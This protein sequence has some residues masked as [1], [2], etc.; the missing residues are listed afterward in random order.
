LRLQDLAG[1][2]HNYDAVGSTRS[3]VVPASYHRLFLRERIGEGRDV[4]ER[5]AGAVMS[6]QMH[7]DLRLEATSPWVQVS[8]LMLGRLG[9][10]RVALPVPCR[11]VWTV[12]EPDRVGFAYGTLSGHPEAGEESFV[13][14]LEG[15][16]VWLTILAYSRP[17]RWF[18]R[19]GGPL[20]RAGQRLF[21]R[22]YVARLRRL[23]T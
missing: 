14:S 17:G 19:L 3:A 23:A 21:A 20:S 2:R 12:E 13:V 6:W 4:F 8:A 5:A 10:G 15:D 16:A 1:L 18:T 22:R 11:V 7:G 9:V